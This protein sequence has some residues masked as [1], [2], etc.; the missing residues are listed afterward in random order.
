M[1][2]SDQKRHECQRHLLARFHETVQTLET[3]CVVAALVAHVPGAVLS[4]ALVDDSWVRRAAVLKEA[5][6]E[7][8][9]WVDGVDASIWA[10][11]AAVVGNSEEA[12]A[13]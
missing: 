8:L 2:N 5:M 6:L 9:L 12:M 11:L 7:E 1:G 10:I 13:L 3:Y 4:E